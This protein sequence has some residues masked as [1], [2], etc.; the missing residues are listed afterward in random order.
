MNGTLPDAGT[1]CGIDGSPF[2]PS[3]SSSIGEAG[4]SQDGAQV[5]LNRNGGSDNDEALV[6]ALRDLATF[7]D[8]RFSPLHL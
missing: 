5:P 7:D 6:Q 1:W 4:F 3:N 2:D 8:V